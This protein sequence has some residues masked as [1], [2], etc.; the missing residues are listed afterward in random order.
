M[1][2]IWSLYQSF[3]DIGGAE[4][5]AVSLHRAFK[6]H[7][8]T[9][10]LMATN[11]FDTNHSYYQIGK[12]EYLQ[13]SFRNFFRLRDSVVISHHRKVTT[14]LEAIN[15]LFR[16]NIRIIHIAHNEFHDL[17]YLTLFPKEIIAVSD[18]VRQNLIS[19]FNVNPDNITVIYNGLADVYE[20]SKQKVYSDDMIRILYPA[21]IT[22]VKRQVELVD[23]T[24]DLIS[25]NLSISFAGKGE[26]A[27]ILKEKVTGSTQYQFLGFANLE[28]TMYDY[29][30]VLLFSEREGLPLSLI[31]ASLF[32]KPI[33][34]NDV[35]GN[36][37]I[38]RD[39][40]NGFVVN[41]YHDL[42]DLLNKLPRRNTEEYARLAKNSRSL[43]EK[44]FSEK[45]MIEKYVNLIH[46]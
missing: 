23:N 20:V 32:H 26:L 18:R 2:T 6:T 17:K 14:Q 36:T 42:S 19:Y 16:L 38:V 22:K 30:Y 28:E 33:V 11:S 5:V 4:K 10:K 15:R 44:E 13:A 21:R 35:G 24:K 7:G 9:C 43:Y 40:Y 29:D 25:E 46:G 39:G 12:E 1:K 45:V 27:D 41:D 37:E 8:F 31:E 34:C 3:T